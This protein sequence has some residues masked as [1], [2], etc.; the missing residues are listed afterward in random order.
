[1]SA[2]FW[3]TLSR[4]DPRRDL[5]G[6]LLA[7][8]AAA[9][10]WSVRVP[11]PA[12]EPAPPVAAP[13]A[14]ET[15]RTRQEPLAMPDHAVDPFASETLATAWRRAEAD[16]AARRLEE[17]IA[18]RHWDA[19]RNFWRF[20]L[21]PFDLRADP[22][23]APATT[24]Q[25]EPS[26]P[27][28]PHAPTELFGPPAPPLRRTVLYRGLL[29]RPDGSVWGLLEDRTSG[30]RGFVTA[31]DTVAGRRVRDVRRDALLFE[32]DDAEP[33]PLG[34]AVELEQQRP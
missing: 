28:D 10:W 27:P 26:V 8:A 21:E 3:Q 1:M 18:G 23:P 33:L 17:E 25:P 16:R 12:A 24:D 7:L 5:A 15:R 9:A 6:S 19:D 34:V 20:V 4:R 29:V 2:G 31:G 11:E 22:Y 14:E 30:T 32:A 13:A